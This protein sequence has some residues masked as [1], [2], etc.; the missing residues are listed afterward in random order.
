MGDENPWI[1]EVGKSTHEWHCLAMVPCEEEDDVDVAPEARA[2]AFLIAA[3]PELYAALMQV[4]PALKTE[5]PKAY[6][7][8]MRALAKARGEEVV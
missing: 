3:A 8:A 7:D 4:L 5:W 6:S 2:N 1:V